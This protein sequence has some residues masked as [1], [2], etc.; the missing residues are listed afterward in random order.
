MAILRAKIEHCPVILGSA[1]P[2]LEALHNVTLGKS[3]HLHLP[4]RAG[5]ASKPSYH[6]ID[7]RQQPLQAGLSRP[8]LQAMQKHLA[9]GGQVLLFLNRRGY[10]PVLLCHSCGWIA[11]CKHC[12]AYM[13]LH[14]RPAHLSCHHCGAKSPVVSH[15]QA[16]DA[17]NSLLQIGV[18]TER[19]EEALA[20]LL[21]NYRTVRLDRSNVQRKGELEQ[22]LNKVHD[23]EA[24]ILIGT[25]MLAKGHHFE[26][27]TM[28]GVVNLDGGLFS[29]DFRAL[30]HTAQLLLQVAGR[31]GRVEKPGEV[32]IQTYHPEH[33]ILLTLLEQGYGRFAEQMLKERAEA[34]W[35][36]YSHLALLRAEARS[37]EQANAFLKDV[38]NV[39]NS[40][41]ISH[42]IVMGPVPAFM[43]KKAGYHR[44][45]L[46]LR[47]IDRNSLH[48]VLASLLQHLYENP[49]RQLRW[50]M[51]I[52][53]IEVG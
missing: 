31:A 3:L 19:V 14:Q 28:V 27:V 23:R 46:L 34:L 35:P 21:P 37:P 39:I 8:L 4:A 45:Q 7:M 47:S 6:L 41:N 13:T 36:P 24:D 15:C 29:S 33:P 52:D 49:P 44:L 26:H 11:S 20:Q 2:S 42:L 9:A 22:L 53:P 10:A 43:Q 50:H 12:D 38:K 32:Y 30:E 48:Q 40:W 16:C 1:T 51:D 17:D 18:G 5:L 25:Q